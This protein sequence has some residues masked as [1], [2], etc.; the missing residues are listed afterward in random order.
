MQE[1][2]TSIIYLSRGIIIIA[3]FSSYYCMINLYNYFSRWNFFCKNNEGLWVCD[4]DWSF[5]PE[6]WKVGS[7]SG[8]ASCCLRDFLVSFYF[9]SSWFHT[10]GRQVLII[11]IQFLNRH[12]LLW[13]S[14]IWKAKKKQ[15]KG[16][17]LK[18]VYLFILYIAMKG[19][20]H[21]MSFNFSQM[22]Q[23][24][25]ARNKKVIDLFYVNQ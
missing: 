9:R 2:K 16:C 12:E 13:N 17:W 3:C 5:H 8:S 11:R 14:N 22:W 6:I 1:V 25:V 10:T 23:L 18:H 19:T 4:H 20:L 15:V 24:R 21:L 7:S